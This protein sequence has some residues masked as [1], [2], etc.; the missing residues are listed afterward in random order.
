[1]LTTY[2]KAKADTVG[3][4]GYIQGIRDRNMQLVFEGTTAQC[5]QMFKLPQGVSKQ[6]HDFHF[7]SFEQRHS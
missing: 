6:C 1:M 3:V 4:T 2:C 5:T 7:Q